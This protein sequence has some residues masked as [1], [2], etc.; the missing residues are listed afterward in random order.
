MVSCPYK[1]EYPWRIICKH[2]LCAALVA[3]IEDTIFL[4]LDRGVAVPQ[5]TRRF[6]SPTVYCQH[7]PST[8]SR[9]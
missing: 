6:V 4:P 1:H 7:E 3:G 9:P 2:E 5:R 8:S